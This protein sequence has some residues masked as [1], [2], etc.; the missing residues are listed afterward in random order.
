[1]VGRLTVYQVIG[2]RLPVSPFPTQLGEQDEDVHTVA[3]WQ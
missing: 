1:M 2:V 3:R